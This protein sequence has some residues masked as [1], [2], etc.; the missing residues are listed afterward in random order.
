[1]TIRLIATDL[2]GT[3][4]RSDLSVSERTRKALDRARAA[5]IHTAPV[6]ARQSHGVRM[7]AQ[8][9]GFDEYALCGN[10]PH[11]VYREE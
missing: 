4:L 9:A 5:G 8:A 3:L 7:I 11:G 2:D 6:V 10:G 1:M